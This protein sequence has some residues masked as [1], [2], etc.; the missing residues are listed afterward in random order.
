MININDIRALCNDETIKA[1]QHFTNRIIKRGIDYDD[2]LY[3]IMNGEIIEGYPDDYPFPSVLIY[4][5]TADNKPLH[6]VVG[7][8]GGDIYLITS[9]WPSLSKW[10]NDY[11]TRKVV[12]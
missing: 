4:G 7:M 8:G 10:E 11:R 2:I 6:T 9:Y 5:C 3:I 1:T 12:K